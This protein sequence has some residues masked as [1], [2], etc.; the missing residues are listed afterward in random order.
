MRRSKVKEGK[1]E[2]RKVLRPSVTL[3]V[4][5]EGRSDLILS[6]TEKEKPAFYPVF[7][8]ASPITPI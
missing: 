3:E 7:L 4:G 1:K 5:S 6:A 8:L 2:R